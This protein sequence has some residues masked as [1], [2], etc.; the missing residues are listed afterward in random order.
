M[1]I[2]VDSVVH[3]PRERVFAAYRDDLAD[4]I[5]LLPNVRSVDV[6]SR[7]VDGAII[8]MHNTFA[9]AT[10]LPEALMRA[11]ENRFLQ[12][13][14]DAVWNESTWICEWTIHTSALREAVSCAGRTE[15]IDVGNGR[16]RLELRGDLAIDLR[17]VR[18]PAFLAASLGRTLESFLVR[19]IASNLETV[20]EALGTHLGH[21]T[22]P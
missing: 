3:Q 12:W 14:D 9:G 4:L 6:Q 22:Q 18:V 17:R 8:R 21:D 7:V 1:R 2:E 13:E 20:A 5:D 10:E 19:H 16:T 15:F 11:F